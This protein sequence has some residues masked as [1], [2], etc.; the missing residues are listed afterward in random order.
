MAQ[1]ATRAAKIGFW[2]LPHQKHAPCHVQ[3][4]FHQ[5][6]GRRLCDFACLPGQDSAR[7][8]RHCHQCSASR[9][10]PCLELDLPYVLEACVRNCFGT[11]IH[12]Y[13]A[14]KSTHSPSHVFL[15][16][17]ILVCFGQTFLRCILICWNFHVVP[18][19]QHGARHLG[20]W[21]GRILP[22]YGLPL[23][24][25]HILLLDHL[26]GRDALSKLLSDLHSR[27]Q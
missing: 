13:S 24:C 18:L 22:F 7:H 27:R 23:I 1:A 19:L 12:T 16:A 5:Q 10:T 3:P 20:K 6:D 26:C 4:P 17:L 14:P 21:I 8:N 9:C 15:G 2:H 25:L 11:W